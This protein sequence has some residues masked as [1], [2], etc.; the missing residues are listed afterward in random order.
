MQI[1]IGNPDD[2]DQ[3]YVNEAVQLTLHYVFQELNLYRLTVF[4]ADDDPLGIQLLQKHG[5]VEEVRR[6]QAIHRDGKVCDSLLLGLLREEWLAQQ[7]NLN[8]HN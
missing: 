4:A 3:A 6:R 7:G 2:R 5:F 1:G 8:D